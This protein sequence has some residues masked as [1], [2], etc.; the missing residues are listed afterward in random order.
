MQIAPYYRRYDLPWTPS[1]D[2]ERGYRKLQ[3]ALLLALLLIGIII[4]LLPRVETKPAKPSD[5]PERVVQLIV[6]KPLPPPPPPPPPPEPKKTEAK[7][8]PKPSPTKQV[9]PVEERVRQVGLLAMQDDLA[10]LRQ[11]VEIAKTD[12][13]TVGPDVRSERN[14]ITSKVGGASS[15]INT[16]NMSRG[17]GGG[18]GAIGTHT[19]ASVAVP[20]SLTGKGTGDVRRS[21]ASGKA[22]RSREEI[23]TVFDRNKGALYAL[24]TRA[25]R[26]N[27][28]LQGKLVLEL[29]I[30]PSGEV[31]MARVVSSELKDPELERK[32]VARVKLFRFEARDV[33]AITATKPIDFFPA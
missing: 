7:P 4:P 23:E 11:N 9:K 1:E 22:S 5:L 19:T 18:A 20:G 25:Q 17:Y 13:K 14:L 31:T 21:G 30:A 26:D 10:A 24:Y 28:E 8:E 15:G 12:I 32:I 6:E 27:P 29:T 16:A 2:I 3:R 33:E